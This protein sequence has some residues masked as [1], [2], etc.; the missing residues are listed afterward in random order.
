MIWRF[1]DEYGE[2]YLANFELGLSH[3]CEDPLGGGELEK[4]DQGW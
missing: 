1:C 4:L 2:W 3:G